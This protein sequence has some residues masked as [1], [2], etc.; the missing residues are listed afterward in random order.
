MIF[1]R[2]HGIRTRAVIVSDHD[3]AIDHW[4]TVNDTVQGEQHSANPRYPW[5]MEGPRGPGPS[6]VRGN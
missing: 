2:T 6:W 1:N 3:G 5:V 4:F